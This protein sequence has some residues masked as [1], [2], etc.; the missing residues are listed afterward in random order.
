MLLHSWTRLFSPLSV[1]LG[2][3]GQV[4]ISDTHHEFALVVPRDEAQRL[5]A[6]IN[7]AL[8]PKVEQPVT[9]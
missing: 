1:E 2:A 5:A 9:Q 7:H 6:K 4:R 8:E 3:D